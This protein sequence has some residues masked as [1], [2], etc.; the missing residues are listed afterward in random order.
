VYSEDV[1]RELEQGRETQPAN[2]LPFALKYL[3]TIVE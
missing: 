2:P 3:E 1:G